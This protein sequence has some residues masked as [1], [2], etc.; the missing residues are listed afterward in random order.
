MTAYFF[1]FPL[2]APLQQT[3]DD[4]LAKHARGQYV[5]PEVSTELALGTTDGIIQAMALDVI[6]ILKAG[7]ESAGILDVLAR[8][9][10]GTMHVL[11]R[12][13]M[14][15]VTQPEQDKLAGY[16]SR[17][18]IVINSVARFGFSLP[19]A[20]GAR[21]DN[22]LQRIT[23]GHLENARPELTALMSEFVELAVGHFYDDFINSLDLG[24]V[25]RKLTEVGRTTVSKGSLT[26]VHKLFQS[27][28]DADLQKVAAHY[29][30]MFVKA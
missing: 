24:F 27:M 2:H 14:G 22:L 1:S 10:K 7:G 26:A 16:L 6:D 4:L 29:A 12:Q 21:F 25:K 15:K 17:R 13:I 8:L 19:E 5:A 3:L 30:T 23:A 18:R 9:L 20:V 28:T 11:I